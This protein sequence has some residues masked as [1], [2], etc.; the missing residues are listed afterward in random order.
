MTGM[1]SEARVM[2]V[3]RWGKFTIPA[4]WLYWYRKC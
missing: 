3:S 1:I 4:G 2:S